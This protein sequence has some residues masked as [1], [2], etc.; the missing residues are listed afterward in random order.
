MPSHVAV[1]RCGSSRGAAPLAVA[2]SAG[3]TAPGLGPA[4]WSLTFTGLLAVGAGLWIVLARAPV[5]PASAPP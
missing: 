1:C 4:A 3:T 2:E 5:P